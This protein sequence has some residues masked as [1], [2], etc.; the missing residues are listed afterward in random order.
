M[1]LKERIKQLCNL[2]HISMNKLEDTL[3][4]GKG[5]IS[6]L[7]NSNPNISKIQKIA[8]YFGV[9]VDYLLGNETIDPDKWDEEA[10][11]FEDKISAFYYQ[12][13]GLGWNYES[14]GDMYILSNNS[15]SFK[16]TDNEFGSFVDYMEETCKK[17]LQRLYEKSGMNLF[18]TD[19]VLNAAHERTDIKVTDEMRRHDEYLINGDD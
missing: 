13:R 1:E 11:Q 2:Q 18:Q 4:F 12:L 10:A 3:G 8:D 17:R 15:V 9:T 7:N 14:E 6:K 5:Y 19:Q 16:I